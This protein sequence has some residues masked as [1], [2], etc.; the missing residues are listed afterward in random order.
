MFLQSILK[1]ESNFTEKHNFLSLVTNDPHYGTILYMCVA[2]SKN[3][4]V[5]NTVSIFMSNLLMTLLE[6]QIPLN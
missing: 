5:L 3:S 1:K 4:E 6:A 2:I